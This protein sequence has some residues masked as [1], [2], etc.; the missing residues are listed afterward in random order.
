MV[1][2][3]VV[4]ILYNNIAVIGQLPF[5]LMTEQRD[6]MAAIVRSRAVL[7]VTGKIDV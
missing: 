7:G 2:D 5:V 3:D 6:V 4:C 1:I